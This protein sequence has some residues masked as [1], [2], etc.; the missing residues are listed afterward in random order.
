MN[1]KELVE[2]GLPGIGHAI[3]EAAHCGWPAAGVA[4]W[5]KDGDVGI[6]TWHSHEDV[7]HARFGC[8]T[9]GWG[10]Q[11]WNAWVSLARHIIAA[12]DLMNAR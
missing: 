1:D 6:R 12:D 7:R 4:I 2:A 10:A 9:C 8:T 3:A 5:P 11:S